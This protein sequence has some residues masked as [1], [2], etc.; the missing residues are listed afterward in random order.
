MIPKKY[1]PYVFAFFMSSFMSCVMSFVINVVNV[2]FIDGIVFI[3][4]KSWALAFVVAFPTVL[5]IA[6][7]AR[8]LVAVLVEQ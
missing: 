4:L 3:W 5:L 2:G 8:K 7:I 1:T 6:P